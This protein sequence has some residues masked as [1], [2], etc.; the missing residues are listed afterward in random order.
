MRTVMLT[1]RYDDATGNIGLACNG[2]PQSDDEP[3]VANSGVLIAHDLIEHVNGLKR[4]GSIHD[5][6]Q[7]LG[8][9]WFTRGNWGDIRRDRH[10]DINSY[11][12]IGRDVEQLAVKFVQRRDEDLTKGT[13]KRTKRDHIQDELD[14]CIKEGM[15]AA[16][17]ELAHYDGGE[18][19]YEDE[20]ARFS[21]VAGRLMRMGYDKIARKYETGLHANTLFWSIAE[22]VD[23]GLSAE[24]YEGERFKL[25]FDQTGNNEFDTTFEKVD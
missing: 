9:V 5:E 12:A 21:E 6:L 13:P 1:A 16:A 24:L 2:L 17:A 3:M 10:T 23:S 18:H 11:A 19:D 7:A 8:A 14:E 4:I 22:A 25:R 15:K 20:L